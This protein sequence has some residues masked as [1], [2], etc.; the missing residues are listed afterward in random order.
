MDVYTF[1][2][3]PEELIKFAYVARRER[4]LENYY[5][6]IINKSHLNQIREYVKGGR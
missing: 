5:Q 6:R 2:M 4:G 1:V 3:N